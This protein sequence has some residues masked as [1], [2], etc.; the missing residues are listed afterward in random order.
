MMVFG[1][2]MWVIMDTIW[3]YKY[4]KVIYGDTDSVF[5]KIIIEKGDGNFIK[6]KDALPY[7]FR[8]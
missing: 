6:G 8:W 3:D 2:N 1:E 7:V 4:G 5:V